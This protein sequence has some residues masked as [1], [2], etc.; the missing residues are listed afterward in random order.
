M[1]RTTRALP[2]GIYAASMSFFDET[3]ERIDTQ[4]QRQHTVRLS[5]AGIDGFVVMGSNGEAPHLSIEERTIIIRKTRN[6]LD[7]IGKHQTPIIAGCSENSVRGTVHLCCEAS[8]AGSDYA[9]VLPPSYFSKGMSPDVI[10]SFF[11]DVADQS[12]IPIILYSFPAVSAGIEMDSDLLSRISKHP[13]VAGTKFTCG[14]TGK[15]SRVSTAM[16]TRQFYALFGGLADFILPALVAGASGVIAGGANVTPR[17]C[18]RVFDLW[19]EGL[20]EEAREMQAILAKGDWEHTARGISGTKAALNDLFGKLRNR[21]SQQAFRRRRDDLIRELRER[22]DNNQTNES[23]A[24]AKLRRENTALRE[25]L[26]EAHAKLNSLLAGVQALVLNTAPRLEDANDEVSRMNPP[27][28]NVSASQPTVG[29]Q[30]MPA[31]LPPIPQSVPSPAEPNPSF[32]ADLPPIPD[33]GESMITSTTSALSI[34][35]TISRQDVM[36]WYTKT[37][38]Y[39]TR[40][41]TVWEIRPCDETFDRL[42]PQYQPTLLQLSC[43]YPAVIDWLPFPSIRDCLVR[44]HAGNPCIDEVVSDVVSMYAVETLL[45]D[46]VIDAPPLQVYV[47]IMDLVQA[48]GAIDEDSREGPAPLPTSKATDIFKISSVALAVAN[49]LQI[50]TRLDK[51]KLDPRLFIRHPE[52]L[53]SAG[54][55]MAHGV[56]L[57]PDHPSNLSFPASMDNKTASSYR[58][59][60]AFTCFNV[61]ES[62]E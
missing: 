60:I 59:F 53:E 49:H 28:D 55:L 38:F 21:L 41:I 43:S 25:Q 24:L 4:T 5:E 9:L 14:D 19:Q 62:R 7:S 34:F 48:M 52:F 17:T 46:L 47:K 44:Y 29:D 8:R 39:Y 45:S 51:Y 6:A 16:K 58:N 50:E 26:A 12:P 57:Q 20:V 40:D 35:H 13:N 10:E 11:A 32:E 37:R 33:L 36:L 56:P 2:R 22:A 15:L 54:S 18:V 30:P 61:Y 3:T 31:D 1:K 27:D 42:H 23:E